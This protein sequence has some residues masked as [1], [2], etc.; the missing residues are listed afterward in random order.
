MTQSHN[1]HGYKR[2]DITLNYNYTLFKIKH[3]LILYCNLTL[4]N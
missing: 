1:P 2:G 4:Q 3:H